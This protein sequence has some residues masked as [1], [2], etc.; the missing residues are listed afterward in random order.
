MKEDSIKLIYC[1]SKRE[2]DQRKYV[3][4]PFILL[5]LL[6]ANIIFCCFLYTSKSTCNRHQTEIHL[7]SSINTWL[8][9]H[10]GYLENMF[11]VKQSKKSSICFNCHYPPTY[12]TWRMH[13]WKDYWLDI[14]HKMTMAKNIHYVPSQNLMKRPTFQ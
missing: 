8:L 3:I 6:Y 5:L 1:N 9:L 12:K 11:R 2:I 4:Y 13:E 7:Y 14:S 10:L